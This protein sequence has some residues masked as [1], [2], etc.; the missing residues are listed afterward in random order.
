MCSMGASS[1]LAALWRHPERVRA[2]GR[3]RATSDPLLD[4]DNTAR[5]RWRA[6]TAVRCLRGSI[7][8][9]LS[10]R[11]SSRRR[12]LVLFLSRRGGYLLRDLNGQRAIRRTDG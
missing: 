12:V 8:V 3:A 4:E 5:R 11:A 9:L 6:E 10:R 2:G 7:G 1:P